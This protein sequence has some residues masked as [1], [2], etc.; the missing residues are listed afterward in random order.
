MPSGRRRNAGRWRARQAL[1]ELRTTLGT[2]TSLSASLTPTVTLQMSARPSP[3][4]APTRP[5]APVRAPD[6]EPVVESQVGARIVESPAE[7]GAA[8]ADV[9]DVIIPG[10]LM[11]DDEPDRS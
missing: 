11:R 5:K 3:L 1:P 6:H 10:E 4:P 7:I 9:I 2:G 8:A